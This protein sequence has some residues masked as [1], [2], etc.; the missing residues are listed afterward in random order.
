MIGTDGSTSS[1]LA[2]RG[3]PF[4]LPLVIVAALF[5]CS[6]ASALVYQVLWLRTLGW[7][8]GVTVYAASTVWACFMGGLALGSA[9]GGRLADRVRFPLRWFGAAEMLVGATAVATP[10]AFH[11]L[12]RAWIALYPTIARAPAALTAGRFT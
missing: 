9:L 7:V 2:Q 11:A 1:P 3:F 6:G 5:F 8:F 4:G 10:V 12:Q